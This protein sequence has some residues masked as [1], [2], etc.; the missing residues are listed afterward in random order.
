MTCRRPLSHPHLALVQP[1]MGEL[2]GWWRRRQPTC[3]CGKRPSAR[4]PCF[5]P[6]LLQG[7]AQVQRVGPPARGGPRPLGGVGLRAARRRGRA[8]PTYGISRRRVL[9]NE[10]RRQDGDCNLPRSEPA[11]VPA[12]ASCSAHKKTPAGCPAGGRQLN[13]SR[14]HQGTMSRCTRM[15]RP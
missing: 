6:V 8:N 4:L 12:Y 13:S 5:R 9:P 10:A 7:T 11:L 3:G 2:L 14:E 15:R 1:E